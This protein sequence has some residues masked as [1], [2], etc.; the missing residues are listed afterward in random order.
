MPRKTNEELRDELAQ[1][2]ADN[3]RLYAKVEN[4]RAELSDVEE[5]AD[6]D[7]A[8]DDDD[9]EASDEEEAA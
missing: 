2:R 8:S 9:D 5:D 6:D 3:E 4:L 1:E 7:E